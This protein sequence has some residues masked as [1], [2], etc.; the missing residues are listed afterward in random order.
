LLKHFLNVG[1]QDIERATKATNRK[2]L[3]FSLITKMK[4]EKGNVRAQKK[5]S[6]GQRESQRE[7]KEE[8]E[9]R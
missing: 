9:E 7:R 1:Q 6:N 8:T 3:T 2:F 4:E 5:Q